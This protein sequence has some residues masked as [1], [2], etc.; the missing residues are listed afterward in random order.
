MDKNGNICALCD[1]SNLNYFF[2]WW[3]KNE[4]NEED[5]EYN[6]NGEIYEKKDKLE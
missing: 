1:N 4:E 2:L 6:L 3:K 5:E